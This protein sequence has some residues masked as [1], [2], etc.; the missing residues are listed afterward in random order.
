M[1]VFSVST[2]HEAVTATQAIASGDTSGLAT[3][4]AK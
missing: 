1:Q 4:S 2:L 3:C